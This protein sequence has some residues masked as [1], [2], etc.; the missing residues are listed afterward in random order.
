MSKFSA[1]RVMSWGETFAALVPGAGVLVLISLAE[2]SFVNDAPAV[3]SLLQ[4]PLALAFGAVFFAPAWSKLPIRFES[5]FFVW[6]YA[7]SGVRW[8]SLLRNGVVAFVIVPLIMAL[9]LTS[10]LRWSVVSSL[11]LPFLTQGI[12]IVLAAGAFFNSLGRR[13]R[14]DSVVGVLSLT[15]IL[16]FVVETLWQQRAPLLIWEEKLSPLWNSLSAADISVS[17]GIVWWFAGVVDFPDMRAQ[18]LLAGRSSSAF[19]NPVLLAALV[20]AIVQGW[21]LAFPPNVAI[22]AWSSF[23]MIGLLFV[24]ALVA[25]L[26]AQFW[27]GSAF[28]QSLSI[29]KKIPFSAKPVSLIVMLIATLLAY[30]LIELYDQSTDV[31]MR[32]VF[33]SAGVGPVYILRWTWWRINAWVQIAAMTGALLLG[34]LWPWIIESCFSESSKSSYFL[35]WVLMPG[36]VNTLLWLSV[37]FITRN[38]VSKTFSLRRIAEAGV[39]RSFQRPSLWCKWILFVFLLIVAMYWSALVDAGSTC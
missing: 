3:L 11:Q 8:L 13:M 4:A 33:F 31:V 6:R 1:Q 14:T 30:A 18:K 39:L 17:L 2:Q 37:L 24:N 29:Q 5:E 28:T 22:G 34:I 36:A 23:I 10:L 12:F 35:W 20:L 19:F 7:D 21:F 16:F 9:T 32:I 26:D 15:A 25:L 27:A 38:E